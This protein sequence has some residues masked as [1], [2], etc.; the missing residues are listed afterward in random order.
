MLELDGTGEL[1]TEQQ[2]RKK[3]E[4]ASISSSIKHIT[5]YK[6]GDNSQGYG[7]IMVKHGAM[8]KMDER[9]VESYV[10]NFL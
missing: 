2:L 9:L 4:K 5:E 7:R 1:Y 3:L 10:K 6:Y 8:Y